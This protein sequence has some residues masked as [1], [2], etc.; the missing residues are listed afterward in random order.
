MPPHPSFAAPRHSFM[1]PN[2]EERRSAKR[3]TSGDR[4]VG[5]GRASL[6]L[7][8]PPARK[9]REGTRSPFGAPPRLSPEAFR[10][11]GSASGHAS[12]DAAPAGV[13]R[14]HLSQSRDCTSR[15]GRSTGVT[16]AR[17][18]PGAGR[19][20]ARRHRPRSAFRS[21]L[22]KAPF[23]ERDGGDVTIVGTIVKNSV[24]IKETN[25]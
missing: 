11:R 3:R 21:T 14:L 23:V 1:P 8:H 16:D 5:C 4:I 18:R 17:S 25:M 22:A 10:P 19:N 24:S 15:A 12:L 13:T 9:D 20:A 2:K 6:L 7:P